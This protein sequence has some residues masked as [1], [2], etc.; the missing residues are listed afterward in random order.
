[1]TTGFGQHVAKFGEAMEWLQ[2]DQ[3]HRQRYPK[4]RPDASALSECCTETLDAGIIHRFSSNLQRNWFMTTGFGQNVEKIWRSN[5]E[6]TNGPR[7]LSLGL[8]GKN[9]C[10]CTQRMLHR[11]SGCWHHPQV[12]Q[13]SSEKLVHDHGIWAQCFEI[14]RSN[15]EVTNG[16][17][18][19]PEAPKG[20]NR[21][22]CTQ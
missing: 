14:R 16:S 13:L 5:G 22:Q 12:F 7:T 6:V 2:T 15:G 21:C 19:L 3:E 11:D 10:Q 18:T 1:M 4:A 9:V 20:K 17:R 8:K